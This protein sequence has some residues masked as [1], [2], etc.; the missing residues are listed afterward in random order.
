RFEPGDELGV[1]VLFYVNDPTA[2]ATY[3]VDGLE[4]PS[5][6]HGPGLP[7]VIKAHPTSTWGLDVPGAV[8]EAA[9][10]NVTTYPVA[11]H[12]P[13][14]EPLDVTLSVDGTSAWLAQAAPST[15]TVPP[16][17]IGQVN[18]TIGAP[19]STLEGQE[20]THTLAARA[21]GEE[22][23]VA[24]ITHVVEGAGTFEPAFAEP[25]G[26]ASEPTVPSGPVDNL[27]AIAS[28]VW[29]EAIAAAV[30]AGL[31]SVVG[32]LRG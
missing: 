1:W 6:L 17:G 21:D 11:V 32:I 2:Q 3:L 16:G 4:A 26:V 30:V 9:P 28:E 29:V 25:L 8:G 15:L 20:A 22:A 24:L 14:G 23:R 31:A 5:A 7:G 13:T 12:N 27:L 19:V 10:G 18:V